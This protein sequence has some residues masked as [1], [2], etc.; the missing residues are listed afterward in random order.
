[1]VASYS[2]VDSLLGCLAAHLQPI[3]YS[4]IYFELGLGSA[5]RDLKK[6][7]VT[8]RLYCSFSLQIVFHEIQLEVLL[9]LLCE[10]FYSFS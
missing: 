6:T 5:M 4:R 2:E 7:K 3:I 9:K 10:L 8:I 1:M